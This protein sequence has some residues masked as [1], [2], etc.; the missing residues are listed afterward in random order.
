M[1]YQLNF[2]STEQVPRQQRLQIL[3]DFVGRQVARRQ[4]RP[5]IDEISIEMSTTQ[6]SDDL[7]LAK[8]HYSPIVGERSSEML[9]DGRDNYLLT[10]HDADCEIRIEGGAPLK[11]RK[12]DVMLV[13]EAT[14]SEFRLPH[15]KVTVLSL[16]FRELMTRLPRVEAKPYYHMAGDA[17]GINLLS[18]YSDLLLSDPDT[19]KMLGTRA[20]SHLYDLTALAVGAALSNDA[21]ADRASIGKARLEMAKTEIMKRLCDPD[22]KVTSIARIQGV[23]PRY[24]QRLFEAEGLSFSEFLRDARLDLA[25][26]LL[27]DKSREEESISALAYDSGFSDL[28]HFNRSFRKR[29][30]RTPSDVRAAAMIRRRG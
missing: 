25:F 12:G 18:G 5:L 29:F 26:E 19:A 14:R 15:I 21:D 22:L 9:G 6:L 30:D 4:F 24:L 28:S 8:A 16:G 2:F 13:N 7:M 17:Q 20:A 10:I 3:H 27:S 1:E 23:T 11:V